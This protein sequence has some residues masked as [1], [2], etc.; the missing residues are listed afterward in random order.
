[1]TPRSFSRQW[2]RP[3]WPVALS[4][5]VILLAGCAS[6]P[7]PT[8]Q[9]AVATAAVAHAAEAGAAQWAPAE[10][11]TARDKLDNAKL[12]MAVP[13][14]ARARS[15]AEEA[16]VDAQLAEAKAHAGK[17]QKAADEVREAGRVLREE[18]GR[19]AP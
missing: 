8:E 11:R 4:A 13:D 3:S 1:M 12:A 7:P 2:L 19:K 15:L 6:T 18:M 17:A 14:H 9:L 5:A 16:Q 10:M